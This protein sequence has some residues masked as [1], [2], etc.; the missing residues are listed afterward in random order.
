M[1]SVGSGDESVGKQIPLDQG[2]DIVRADL[3]PEAFADRLRDVAVIAT[4][5]DLLSYEIEELRQLDQGAVR[6]ASEV[7]GLFVAGTLVL[8]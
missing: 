3:L 7:T 8:P 5:I 4:T 1:G 2:L 6:P